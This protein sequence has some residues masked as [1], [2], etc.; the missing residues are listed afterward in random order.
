MKKENGRCFLEAFASEAQ[1]YFDLY[2]DLEGIDVQQPERLLQIVF[3]YP[4]QR[5]IIPAEALYHH[6]IPHD[7]CN[8]VPP[9]LVHLKLGYQI[10]DGHCAPLYQ[11][12]RTFF[13]KAH[14]LPASH[15]QEQGKRGP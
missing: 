4:V 7:T 5:E 9:M 2:F 13:G 11:R 10:N 8:H 12:S 1:L 3:G 6:D 15:R 14:N